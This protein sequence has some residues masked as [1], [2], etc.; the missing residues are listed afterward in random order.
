M[1]SARNVTR[2]GDGV[3]AA[4]TSRADSSYTLRSEEHTSELQSHVNLVCR[5]LLEKKKT[6]IN[7]DSDI[8]TTPDLFLN[9][10]II[11]H[12]ILT[13]TTDS[14]TLSLHD[15]LPILMVVQRREG[16]VDVVGQERDPPR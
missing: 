1:W 12:F 7:K 11:F 10:Y 5:L 16:E 6:I 3:G 13:S 4:R 9:C 2:P 8:R 15:A 14:Y